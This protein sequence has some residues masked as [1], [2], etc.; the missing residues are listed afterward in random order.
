MPERAPLNVV[1]VN[2]PP[3]EILF[4]PMAMLPA[5]FNPPKPIFEA[6]VVEVALKFPK[7]GVEV[8][9]NLVPSYESKVLLA[10]EVAFVPPLAMARVPVREV[11]GAVKLPKYALVE[12]AVMKDEYMVD[13]EY[14]KVCTPVK[15]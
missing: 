10:Y 5:I 3:P 2:V 1:A 7:V 8:E 15:V 6:S 11:M 4:P 13:E 12:E 9:T 14:E